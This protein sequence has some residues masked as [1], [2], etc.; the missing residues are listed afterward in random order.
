MSLETGAVSRRKLRRARTSCQKVHLG[1]PF[2]VHDGRQR[3]RLGTSAP[4]RGPAGDPPWPPRTAEAEPAPSW[5]P[6]RELLFSRKLEPHAPRCRRAF[7]QRSRPANKASGTPDGF[8]P[9][10][11]LC[12]SKRTVPATGWGDVVSDFGFAPQA[13][14]ER[15]DAASTTD[16][17]ERSRLS[18][19]HSRA[20]APPQLNFRASEDPQAALAQRVTGRRRNG[21]RSRLG[22]APCPTAGGCTRWR[23][24][25]CRPALTVCVF[26]LVSR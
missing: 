8:W 5:L 19:V 26:R 6:A 1:E 7:G 15:R 21:R 24:A 25:V 2:P 23:E 13:R 11:C 3:T 18:C 17:Q 20:P 12:Q 22:C 4:C 16:A 14:G 10:L 9:P